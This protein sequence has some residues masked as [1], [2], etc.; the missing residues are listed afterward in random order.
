MC[1]RYSLAPGEFSEIRIE[2]GVE[3]VSFAGPRYNIA[4]T[5]APG[6]DPPHARPQPGRR[7]VRL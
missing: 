3:P 4:P 1:G 2:F 6:Y 5:W 7:A